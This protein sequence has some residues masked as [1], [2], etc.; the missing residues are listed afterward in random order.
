[1][2]MRVVFLNVQEMKQSL[3]YFYFAVLQ[4]HRSSLVN[5]KNLPEDS[6]V[7]LEKL[8]SYL[9]SMKSA[10]FLQGQNSEKTYP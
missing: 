2:F 6:V 4:F 9:P 7:F 1:M 8:F 10:A 5:I 3:T